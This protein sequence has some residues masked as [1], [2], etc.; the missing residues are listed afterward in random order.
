M[1]NRLSLVKKPAK[2]LTKVYKKLFSLSY[3][4][5]FN[6]DWYIRCGIL[7]SRPGISISNKAYVS[8]RANIDLKVNG[9]FAGGKVSIEAGTVISDGVII[10]PYGGSV[11][12]GNNVFVGPYCLLYGHG[13]LFIG[14]NSLIATHCVLIPANHNFLD[15]NIPINQQSETALGI[16][17]E[18]DVWLGAGVKVLDGVT[19]RKSCVVG[20]G[21]VVNKS[22]DEKSVVGGVP[23]K[24]IKKRVSNE[25]K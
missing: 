9:F 16:K 18:E 8:R 2:L 14:N 12:I 21:A 1:I 19:I 22:F 7:N 25:Y 17:L 3:M 5:L 23:A 15:T 13:G 4:F 10:A 24:L 6:L 20:A 11:V